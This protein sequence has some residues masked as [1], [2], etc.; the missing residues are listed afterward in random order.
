MDRY[1]A[2]IFYKCVDLVI[3]VTYEGAGASEAVAQG[4]ASVVKAMYTIFVT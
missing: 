4:P 1:G 3:K 2:Y